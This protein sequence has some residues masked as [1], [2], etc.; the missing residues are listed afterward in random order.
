MKRPTEEPYRKG[1]KYPAVRPVDNLVPEGQFY[2]PPEKVAPGAPERYPTKKPVDNLAPEGEF[3]RRPQEEAPKVGE[4][5]VS[6]NLPIV[7]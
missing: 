2:V 3:P 4:R 7:N 1:E 6:D 5:C